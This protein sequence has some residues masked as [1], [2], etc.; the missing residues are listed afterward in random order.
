MALEGGEDRA[1]R[2]VKLPARPRVV[3]DAGKA[4][5]DG[6]DV[7]GAEAR[8]AGG[9]IRPQADAG[10]GEALP[11]EEL[12]G[13]GLALGRDIGVAEDALGRDRVAGQDGAAQRLE[14][15]ELRLGKRAIAVLVAGIDQL[16]ADRA[17]I[18]VAGAG[19][20]AAPGMPGAPRLVDELPDRAVLL[21]EVMRADLGVGIAQPVERGG[22]GL[23]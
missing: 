11:G 23:H 14:G 1:R 20:E 6:A 17:V 18:D 16:D 12:A 8:V 15:G 13:I 7:L 2:R 10:L 3:A 22:G 5:L 4:A 9:E 19:P 21:D